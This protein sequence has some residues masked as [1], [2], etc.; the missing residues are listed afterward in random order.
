MSASSNR[1]LCIAERYPLDTPEP[2]APAPGHTKALSP[3]QA[4]TWLDCPARWFYR[5]AL[6]LPEPKSIALAIGSATHRGVTA[7]IGARAT[8]AS[9][10][11]L[12]DDLAEIAAEEIGK[13]PDLAEGE[14]LLA[15]AQV[16]SLV[17][18][19]AAEAL[20]RLDIIAVERPLTGKI[21]GIDVHGIADLITRDG[22]IIDLKT[23]S[24]RPSGLKAAHQLQLTTYAL[25][26]GNTHTTRLDT[27]AKTKTPTLTH[28]TFRVDAQARKYAETVYSH[29]RDGIATG[30]FPPR[31]DQMLCS[32]KYCAH[33]QTCESDNGGTVCD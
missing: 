7:A 19:Y 4:T 17:N 9:P 15:A 16:A 2:T 8:G 26:I 23:S 22:Q 28:Q 20:P 11:A 21:A 13:V 27:L 29:A 25:L 3:S 18:L 33:W 24:K 32:R 14:R 30:L 10:E 1:A 31:R 12:A 5:Y 6:E